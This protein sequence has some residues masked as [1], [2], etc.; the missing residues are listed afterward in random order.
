MV[1][2]DAIV[3]ISLLLRLLLVLWCRTL[4]Y[5][6]Q[7]PARG[8]LSMFLS[9]FFGLVFVGGA[10]AGRLVLITVLAVS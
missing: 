8:F 10:G 5:V 2:W 7:Q 6:R 3:I 1:V 4:F 9:F